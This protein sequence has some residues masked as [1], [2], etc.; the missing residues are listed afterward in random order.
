VYRPLGSLD[1]DWASAADDSSAE[2]AV[3]LA[4]ASWGIRSQL[5]PVDDH[6]RWSDSRPLWIRVDPLANTVA[7]AERRLLAAEQQRSAFPL[8]GQP[9]IGQDAL[10]RLL[11]GAFNRDRLTDLI[12]GL[13]LL[14]V[15]PAREPP[16]S[17]IG[18]WPDA[19][20]ALLRAVTS[21]VIL[22]EHEQREQHPALAV[23]TKIL[24]RLR[25]N[26]PEGAIGIAR[27]RLQAHRFQVRISRGS[28]VTP[29][30]PIALAA[31]LVVPLP[32]ALERRIVSRAVELSTAPGGGLS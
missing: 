23:I 28:L 11:A 22:A 21:P 20:F 1:A 32:Y 5:E 9:S 12:F 25:A 2:F 26:D 18:A 17:T 29:R 16:S 6:G 10:A 19:S 8:G 4:I 15:V 27:R 3:A 24:S 30:D 31:G 7:I 13:S 14:S